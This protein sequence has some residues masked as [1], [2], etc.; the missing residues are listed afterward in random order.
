MQHI[1]DDKAKQLAKSQK[2]CNDHT[3]VI[4]DNTK[5]HGTQIICDN[6]GINKSWFDEHY[7]K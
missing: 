2:V 3:W 5:Y 4:V 7:S 1:S 6:C